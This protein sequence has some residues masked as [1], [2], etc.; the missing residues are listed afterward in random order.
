VATVSPSPNGRAQ[1]AEQVTLPN[2]REILVRPIEPSD[3]PKMVQGF[4]HLSA[5]SRYRRFHQAMQQL[6]DDVLIYL[7]EV[8]HHDHEALVSLDST[9]GDGIGVA[10]YVRSTD[11]P[12]VAEVA[13][14][15]VDIWQRMGVATILLARLVERA[16]AEGIRRFSALVQ[17]DNRRVLDLI[18]PL[19]EVRIQSEGTELLLDIDLPQGP[20]RERLRTVL[21][22]LAGAGLDVTRW[23]RP[24]PPTD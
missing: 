5:E 2:G 23:P 7:T 24:A 18:R 19:G 6:S 12:G 21:R 14:T 20:V 13:V 4:A 9:S 1:R 11:D 10:R 16:R 22:E 15:V 8:D 3:K 17:A